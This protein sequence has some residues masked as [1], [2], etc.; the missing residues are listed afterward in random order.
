LRRYLDMPTAKELAEEAV[1]GE[2]VSARW[3]PCSRGKYREFP[4]IQPQEREQALFSAR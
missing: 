1:I 2:P 4:L 3:I